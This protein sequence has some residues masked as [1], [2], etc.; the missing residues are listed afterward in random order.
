MIWLPVV[1]GFTVAE[2]PNTNRIL[3]ILEPITLPSAISFSPFLA[4]TTLVTNSGSDV[5]TA[6]IVKP[7]RLSAKSLSIPI[8]VAPVTAKPLAPNTTN[9]PPQAIPKAPTTTNKIAFHIFISLI[10]S[11]LLSSVGFLLASITRNII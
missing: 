7:T 8:A 10:S 3:K 5:P 9:S 1:N 2:I 4:A 6:T 11:S